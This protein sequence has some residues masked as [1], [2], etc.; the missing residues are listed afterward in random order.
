MPPMRPPMFLPPRGGGMIRPG[1]APRGMMGAANSTGAAGARG[2]FAR[3]AQSAAAGAPRS[4]GLLSS[5]FGRGGEA[6]GPSVSAA[7]S[8]TGA[9]GAVSQGGASLT[10]I[11]NGT[12]KVLAAGERIVP[13]VRQVQ[14]Y[15]PLIKNLPSMWKMYRGLKAADTS[16]DSAETAPVEETNTEQAEIVSESA[17]LPI[18]EET[19]NEPPKSSSSRPSVPKL[20]I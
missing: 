18:E 5:L 12:Q 20:F 3:G 1:M 2:L 17:A 14:Q 4:G 9:A 15:G 16:T 10:N 7:R 8:V 11:M 6:V 13:M 19:K